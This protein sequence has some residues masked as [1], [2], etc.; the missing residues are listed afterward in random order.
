MKKGISVAAVA[1][2]ILLLV[3]SC[4]KKEVQKVP[5]ALK[6]GPIMDS[7]SGH[8]GGIGQDID[9]N[10]VIPPEVQETWSS[11]T[12][13]VSDK[14][15]NEQKEFNVAIGDEFTVPD[16]NLTVKVGHFLPHFTMSGQIIT[17]AS[18]EPNNPSASIMVR[19]GDNQIF[20][21]SGEWGWLYTNFPTVHPFEHERFE[22][23]LKGG[24]R[25]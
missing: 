23:T 11:V 12:I 16:S 5:Q 24:V 25:G 9:F 15:S 10:I 7:Q 19:D 4:K 1:T 22:L 2:M 20:P 14:T 3:V 18:N 17:S 8:R 21:E 6:Q 13:L